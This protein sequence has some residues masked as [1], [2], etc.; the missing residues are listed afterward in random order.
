M[1]ALRWPIFWQVTRKRLTASV[2]LLAY[3]A[4]SSG[5]PLPVAIAIAATHH[6]IQWAAVLALALLMIALPARA[7]AEPS[8]RPT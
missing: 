3:L 4:V 2:A 8:V 7:N 1:R 5:L 6:L